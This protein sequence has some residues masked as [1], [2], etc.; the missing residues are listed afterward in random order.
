MQAK[1]K[2]LTTMAQEK[3]NAILQ[4]II[5]SL[6][7]QERE[8]FAQQLLLSVQQE[9]AAMDDYDEQLDSHLNHAIEQIAEGKTYSSEEAEN[10]RKQFGQQLFN[11]AV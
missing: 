2:R 9:T 7:V 1:I 4:I 5:V 3:L 10:I 11:K 6:P 8:W